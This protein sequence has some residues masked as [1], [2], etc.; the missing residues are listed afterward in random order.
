MVLSKAKPEVAETLPLSVSDMGEALRLEKVRLLYSNIPTNILA[1]LIAAGIFAYAQ[2]HFVDHDLL[3]NWI[4]SLFAIALTRLGLFI[5]YQ[6]T[7][8]PNKRFWQY[9]FV[10]TVLITSVIWATAIIFLISETNIIS[11]VIIAAVIMAVAAGS[12]SPLSYLRVAGL[13][14]LSIL[15]IPLIYKTM[16][17]DNE[18]SLYLGLIYTVFSISLLIASLRYN[19]YITENIELS[20]K[21]RHDAREIRDAKERAEQANAAKTIFLSS[22]SHELRTPMNAIMGF[23]QIIKIDR[24][25]TLTSE[26]IHNLNE[27][28]SASENLLAL[29]DDILD[30]SHLESGE[31][32]SNPENTNVAD[33][34]NSCI[35]I[36]GHLVERK[37]L[38]L[39]T[40]A[41]LSQFN[42]YA[43]PS[44]LRKTLFNLLRNAIE[45]NYES[46]VITISA[47]EVEDDVLISI[48]DTG[49]G[50]AEKDIKELYKPFKRLDP[51]NNVS[52]VGI[53][54]S[55]SLQMLN[56]M[57][58]SIDVDS[59]PGAG[60]CFT[61]T[62]PRA[63]PS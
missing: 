63:K 5:A 39:N 1:T 32:Y 45:Y 4:L 31:F 27:I 12:V 33:A 25:K 30:L 2:S 24:D 55:L 6:I 38:T 23:T 19:R 15:T 18:Y 11:Q 57:N 44:L 17:I 10:T 22:M 48:T 41:D 35:P 29:I 56:V 40:S 62:L 28:M 26:Q 36:I 3:I 7:P 37:H 54:L 59:T 53:G 43:D 46:G 60:S 8:N 61:I 14:F 49:K 47:K 20:Y 51:E 42:V 52:G 50:I 13:G 34:V 16:T 9:A 58:G 21:S